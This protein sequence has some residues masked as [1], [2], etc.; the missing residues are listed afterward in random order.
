M[1][2]EDCSHLSALLF[3]TTHG[4]YTA[5]VLGL[6]QDGQTAAETI[7]AVEASLL[8]GLVCGTGCQLQHLP[9]YSTHGILV[10]QGAV[11]GSASRFQEKLF[12]EKAKL[13]ALFSLSPHLF[14]SSACYEAIPKATHGQG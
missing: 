13:E 9:T 8:S 14:D 10:W 11:C 4:L 5:N 3:D 7:D 6:S 2:G 1:G 12:M